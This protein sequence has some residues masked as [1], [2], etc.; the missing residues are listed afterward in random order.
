MKRFDVFDNTNF[1]KVTHKE[2]PIPH[3]PEPRDAQIIEMIINELDVGKGAPN[4]YR[5]NEK[6]DGTIKIMNYRGEA[7]TGGTLII[8]TQA[9]G[10]VVTEIADY[11][12]DGKLDELGVTSVIVPSTVTK[13]GINAFANNANLQSIIFA[14][15]GT[16]A[17]IG[18]SAFVNCESLLSVNLPAT[19]SIIAHRAFNNCPSLQSI[20]INGNSSSFSIVDGVPD[21]NNTNPDFISS[22]FVLF[23]ALDFYGIIVRLK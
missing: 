14:D 12:F 20:T 19:V 11:A 4:G 17:E 23:F 6:E 16:L 2:T 10:K 18:A 15:S 8:P 5:Y 13:I 7:V 3:F 22:G 21:R 9:E 1:E